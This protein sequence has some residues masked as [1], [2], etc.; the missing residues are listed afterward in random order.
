MNDTHLILRPILA[1][2]E[3][4]FRSA[5]QEFVEA[6]ANERFAFDYCEEEPFCDY[7]KRLDA[8]TRGEG[9][10]ENF[11]PNT[12]L[13]GVI[14]HEIIGRVSIRHQLNE[15]ITEVG[16]HIGYAVVP[17]HQGRGHASR[18]LGLALP[19]AANLGVKRA[20][21]T[22]HPDNLPSRRAIERNG[23]VFERMSTPSRTEESLRRY[24]IDCE[25]S[26]P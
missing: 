7:L 10:P 12:F 21:L 22:C 14:G 26:K 13:I 11:V 23:G 4:A 15:L 20:L 24:W 1:S 19:M 25:S 9:L 5:Q 3:S 6:F 18:M 16:G 8:W 2:D 17:R